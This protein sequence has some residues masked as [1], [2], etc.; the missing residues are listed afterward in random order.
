MASF[1]TLNKK[2][3]PIAFPIDGIIPK[4]KYFFPFFI[5]VLGVFGIPLIRRFKIQEIYIFLKNNN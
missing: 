3:S 2:K 1:S 4:I 5:R